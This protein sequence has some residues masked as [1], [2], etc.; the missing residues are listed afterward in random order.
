MLSVAGGG[1]GLL[2]ARWGLD[3]LMAL[4]PG[5]VIAS[6]RGRTADA[7]HE[8]DDRSAEVWPGLPLV[9]AVVVTL[10]CRALRAPDGVDAT[11]SEDYLVEGPADMPPGLAGDTVTEPAP[12]A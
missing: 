2:Q 7:D 12:T 11:S 6:T 5:Q 10:V 9:V 1:A 3:L 8:F 4:S